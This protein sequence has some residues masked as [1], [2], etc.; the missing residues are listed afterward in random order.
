MKLM[1]RTEKHWNH[2]LS[3]ILSILLIKNIVLR[4]LQKAI[5]QKFRSLVKAILPVYLISHLQKSLS[6][7]VMSKPLILSGV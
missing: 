1:R 7:T 5:L 6:G 3:R 2:F 4:L